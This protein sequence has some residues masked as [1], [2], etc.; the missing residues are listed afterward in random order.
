MTKVVKVYLISKVV[1]ANG[2]E[3][4]Y[5]DV[6]EILQ[7]LQNETRQ[8]KNKIVQLCWEWNNFQSD[9]YKENG[10]YPKDKEVLNYSFAGYVYDK[11]KNLTI[12]NSANFSLMS[13]DVIKAFKNSIDDIR[14][15]NKSIINY[16][17]KQPIDLHNKSISLSYDDKKFF[18]NLSLVNNGFAK[19]N[20]LKRFRFECVVKDNSTRTILER[21]VDKVYKISGSKLSYDKKKYMW[22][23]SL[24]YSFENNNKIDLDE[25]K[26]LGIDLGVKK[27]LVASVYNDFDRLDISG[28][29]ITK[30]RNTIE[31]RRKELLRQTKFSG[32]GKIGHGRNTRCKSIDKLSD[33]ISCFR[34]CANHKYSRAVIDYAIKKGCGIIQMEE[35]S[36]ISEEAKPFLKNWSYFDLQNK[37]KYKANEVGIKVIAVSPS[38]TSQ[39]CSKCGNIDENNRITQASFK[40][41]SCGYSANADYNASQNLAI[42]DIDKIISETRANMK[43]T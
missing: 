14:K 38:Y 1:N 19:E 5:K 18:V 7:Q 13:Q 10:N 40:C 35:L 16:K 26:I 23:M 21:C 39:R 29:E 34:D 30:F 11:I 24:C 36:G 28:R 2:E 37:I 41:T 31:K 27:A 25:N 42:R 22:Y 15:G 17:T 3:V 12:L 9:Y 33:K 20:N 4:K 8:L 32:D 43:Q 6:N